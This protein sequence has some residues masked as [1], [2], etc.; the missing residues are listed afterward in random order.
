M[1]KQSASIE[2]VATLYVRNVPAEL[3]AKLQQ[4]AAEDGHSLNSAILEF[5]ERE[6]ARRERRAELEGLLEKLSTYPPAVGA[7]KLI[8]VD[9]DRGHKPE[10]GY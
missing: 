9:R 2:D 4:L 8:R 10:F 7:E 5:L 1:S 3:Y 6:V